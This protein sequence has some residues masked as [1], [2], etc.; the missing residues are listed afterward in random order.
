[1]VSSVNSSVD[2]VIAVH[3]RFDLL[4]ECLRAIPAATD[5]YGY[6]IIIV[7]NGSPPDIANDFYFSINDPSIK[8][9]RNKEN[10]G[11]PKACNQGFDRGFSQ[12]VFFLNDDVIL[13]PKSIRYLIE[14]M[15]NDAKI[16]V[17]GMKLIFPENTDLPQNEHERPAGKI[18]HIG[19]ATNIRAEFV[20]Q[21]LGW[22]PDHPKVNAM[23]DVYA[24]T[25]AA[26]MT[27]RLLFT[28]AGKFYEG[29]GRGTYEDVDY[30][31]AVH[32]MGYN[33]VVVPEAEGI[34]HTGAT[35]TTYGIGYPLN[36]NRAIFLQRWQKF[37]DWSEWKHC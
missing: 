22:S 1:L 34:H 10:L 20:H 15:N 28:K 4:A 5:N 29:Y 14:T 17:A 7:D 26:L 9:I 13:K 25:G 6:R 12:L 37:L 36:E 3:Q 35:A 32:Q 21:F 18:Q 8:I 31:L 24:V 33:V 16:G 23:R 27:R 19:L 30:C 11:F 2:I